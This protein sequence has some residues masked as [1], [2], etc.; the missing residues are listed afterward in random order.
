MGFGV[1][2]GS[3]IVGVQATVW[4]SGFEYFSHFTWLVYCPRV[5]TSQQEVKDLSLPTCSGHCNPITHGTNEAIL[6]AKSSC[7]SL[8]CGDV[9]DFLSQLNIHFDVVLMMIMAEVVKTYKARFVINISELGEDDP[10]MLNDTSNDGQNDQLNWLMSTLE[11]SNAS[12][13]IIAGFHSIVACDKNIEQMETKEAVEP[14]HRIFLK[15]GV[16]K[17]WTDLLS[18]NGEKRPCKSKSY[19]LSHLT[20]NF[21]ASQGTGHNKCCAL[22]Q[23]QVASLVLLGQPKQVFDLGKWK[24]SPLRSTYPTSIFTGSLWY[25]GIFGAYYRFQPRNADAFV[26]V[27]PA[28]EEPLLSFPE[29][30]LEE[31]DMVNLASVMRFHVERGGFSHSFIYY[32]THSGPSV[33]WVYWVNDVIKNL[34]LNNA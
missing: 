22:Y 7:T 17:L 19:T 24:G 29:A 25:T 12:W 10:L 4:V 21:L 15:Y 6:L 3:I 32:R 8:A 14:L 31:A 11:A 34:P 23:A 28:L 30:S 18:N 16:G 27:A 9:L 20:T 13:R 5:P 26:P 1:S 2:K 33:G